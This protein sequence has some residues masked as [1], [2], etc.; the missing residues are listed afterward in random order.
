[1][2]KNKHLEEKLTSD[3]D[4]KSSK[5]E[6]MVKISRNNVQPHTQNS[7]QASTSGLEMVLNRT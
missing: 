4:R 1:M 2:K 5:V 6:Q 7:K 3:M